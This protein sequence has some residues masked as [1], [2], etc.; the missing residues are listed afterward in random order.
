MFLRHWDIADL[1]LSFCDCQFPTG[2]AESSNAVILER[3][4]M[5]RPKYATSH[6]TITTMPIPESGDWRTAVSDAYL[7]DA[8]LG[9]IEEQI[10]DA[11][12]QTRINTVASLPGAERALAVM[13]RVWGEVA[14]GGLPQWFYNTADVRWH[15]WA[16]EAARLMTMPRTGRA[17]ETGREIVGELLAAPERGPL[18]WE[19]YCNLVW[20]A[21][22]A[23]CGSTFW[24][25]ELSDF[26]CRGSAF[27]RSSPDLVGVAPEALA[28]RADEELARAEKERA[29]TDRE[30]GLLLTAGR[31]ATYL[32]DFNPDPA[33][34]TC[35]STQSRDGE[36]HVEY[37]YTDSVYGLMIFCA[38][39]IH[40][41]ED[42]AEE[43]C[44]ASAHLLRSALGWNFNPKQQVVDRNEFYRWG[45]QSYYSEIIV[46]GQPAG[47]G[48]YARSG[49]RRFS[50]T[51][52]GLLF[53][54][55]EDIG[56]ALGDR[57]WKT[58]WRMCTSVVFV[59]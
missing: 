49:A 42:D 52:F 22:E 53:Q 7:L 35:T 40:V 28:R 23:R 56:D 43:G 9:F 16:V 55:A 14:N 31:L 3:R 1:G 29:V 20:D 30:R 5:D 17:L 21:F 24:D 4:R 18:D 39:H 26:E 34:E 27:I 33:R 25:E 15:A 19:E 13:S 45:D 47:F 36:V 12:E 8:V 48:F 11:S 59:W 38:V 2:W 10:D 57:P 54:D 32:D 51:I 50:L 37:K 46:D 44:E 41:S 58:C 6:R